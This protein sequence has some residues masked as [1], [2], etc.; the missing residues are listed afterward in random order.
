L[1]LN[2]PRNL[3]RF[4]Y[5]NQSLSLNQSLP[6]Y[7]SKNHLL[8]SQSLTLH[9]SQRLSQKFNLNLNPNLL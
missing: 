3:P 4:Q 5:F 8:Q 6:L 1:N 2:Q 7:L 9:L